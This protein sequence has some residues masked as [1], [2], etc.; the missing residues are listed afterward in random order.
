MFFLTNFLQLWFQ[1]FAVN[2]LF[3]SA[4]IFLFP[5]LYLVIFIVVLVIVLVF[6]VIV[7]DVVIAINFVVIIFIVAVDLIIGLGC[8]SD[9][10]YRI[11]SEWIAV[12]LSA[13]YQLSDLL[14]QSSPFLIMKISFLIQFYSCCFQ[15]QTLHGPSVVP[16]NFKNR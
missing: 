3:I 16:R 8:C 1:F 14:V 4:V 12:L 2:C 5:I 6:T 15:N 10:I 11:S 9:R 7:V 13:V